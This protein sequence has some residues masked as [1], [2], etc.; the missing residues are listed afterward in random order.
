[1]KP[2]WKFLVSLCFFAACAGNDAFMRLSPD[3]K[4][5]W[6]RCKNKVAEAQCSKQQQ[7]DAVVLSFCISGLAGDYAQAPE[8]RKWVVQHGCPAEMVE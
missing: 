6:N 7:A 3:D 4:D 8:P 1:M 5:I 2:S